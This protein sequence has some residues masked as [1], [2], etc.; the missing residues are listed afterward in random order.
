MSDKNIFEER[1]H[2]LENEYFHKKEQ[3]LIAKMREKVA[4]EEE[5]HQMAETIGVA[6]QEVLEALQELGYTTATVRL[7][8]LVP[9]VQIAWAEGGVSE[10]EHTQILEFAAA[11]GITPDTAAYDQLLEWLKQEPPQEFYDNTLRAVH[12]VIEALPEQ[13]RTESRQS[14]VEYCT[15]IAEISGGILGFGKISDEERLLIARIATEIG[16]T[17]SDAVKRV[18][19][20]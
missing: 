13:Q 12:Y 15:Q 2:A 6:D 8:Y 4:R 3:A 5:R 16:Q 18:I 10:E 1:E 9:L 17:R 11:R 19:E 14:L 7:L 20:G